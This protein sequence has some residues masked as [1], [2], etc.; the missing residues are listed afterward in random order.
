MI[1]SA[2]TLPKFVVFYS[3]TTGKYL[4]YLSNDTSQD[5]VPKGTKASD[6][7][8]RFY[9]EQS[10]VH[11][12]MIHTRCSYNNKYLRQATEGYNGFIVAAADEPED[13]QTKWNSTLFLRE[14]ISS[15]TP[16]TVSLF[17]V[18]LG[19]Y[20]VDTSIYLQ[21]SSSTSADPKSQFQFVDWESLV[22]LPKHL[23][24]RGD[25]ANYLGLLLEETGAGLRFEI[26]DLTNKSIVHEVVSLPDGTVRIKNVSQECY[27]KVANPISKAVNLSRITSQVR[28]LSRGI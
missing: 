11:P 6:P 23:A 22:T 20:A 26:D 18:Y 25:N 24:F 15:S 3:D 17:H 14:I 27:W 8:S 7:G 21:A 5:I 12:A 13:D 10:K 16:N 4:T 1:M 9:V 28:K 2:T 19:F